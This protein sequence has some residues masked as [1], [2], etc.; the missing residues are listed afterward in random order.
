MI[1]FLTSNT[2]H[3]VFQ[4][5]SYRLGPIYAENG[6][7]DRLKALWPR[8]ARMLLVASEPDDYAMSNMLLDSTRDSLAA[9]GLPAKLTMLDNR[10]AHLAPQLVAESHVIQLCGGHVPTQLAF[11]RE[12]GLGK[13]LQNHEGIL[14]GVSAGSMNCA[15]TVYASPEREGEAI[16]PAYERYVEGLGLVELLFLPHFNDIPHLW[17]DGK[18]MMQ[19]IMLPDSYAV[20]FLTIPD[21]SYFL[22]ENGKTSL[23]GEGYWVDQGEILRICSMGGSCP[24]KNGRPCHIM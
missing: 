12:I 6:L 20:P 17:V 24:L 16:D 13:L 23:Y 10:N 5:G 18:R 8:E 7:R 1:L 22:V 11:F 3:T 14:I 4:N 21:G 15:K 2:G 9:S 19:D